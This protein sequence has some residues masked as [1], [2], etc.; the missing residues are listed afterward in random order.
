VNKTKVVLLS[1]DCRLF[2]GVAIQSKKLLKG[3]L[4]TGRYDLVQIAGSMVQQRP[5]PLDYEGIKLY[6]SSDGYGNPSL[7]KQVISFEKPDV[8]IAFSDPRFFAHLFMMDNEVRPVTRLIFYHTWDNEPFPKFNMPWY[9][10]CDE[11]VMLSHYSYELMKSGGLDCQFIPHGMDPSEFYPLDP[12]RVS[13]ERA[14]LLAQSKSQGNDVNFVIFYNNRNIWRKRPGDVMNIFREFSKRHPDVMLLMNTAPV[15]RDGTDLIGVLNDVNVTPAPIIFN[16][17][18]LPS[19]KLN[20]LYNVADVTINISYN[21]GFGLCVAES[22]CAGTPVIAT[23][24]GGMPEQV[25]TEGGDA[26][27]MLEPHVRELFG[28]P[29]A[30]YIYRDY[31]SYDQT[32]AALEEAYQ[33]SKLPEWKRLGQLGR[34][35]IIASYHID[36]TIRKWDEL[37]Q[38]TLAKPSTYKPWRLTTI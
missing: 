4:R 34:D 15:D 32:L 9:S 20:V 10:A 28:V 27:I 35:H 6:P 8:F 1:D 31:V 17:N 38:T 30:S 29:G 2:S 36:N 13:Q 7:I 14:G 21:E 12:R 26:G 16:F 25:R 33:K 19:E 11:I 24:T 23:R 5:E 18:P 3:L 22:L 37:I